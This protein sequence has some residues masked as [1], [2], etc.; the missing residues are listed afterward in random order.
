MREINQELIDKV[1]NHLKK[2]RE[3]RGMSLM[4]VAAN[5]GIDKNAYYRIER[6]EVNTSVSMLHQVLEGMEVD[7]AEFFSTMDSKK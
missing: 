2:L 6:G 7:L 5:A 4:D 1:G 3:N